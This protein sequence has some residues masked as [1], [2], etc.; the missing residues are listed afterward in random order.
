MATK[1]RYRDEEELVKKKEKRMRSRTKEI[2]ENWVKTKRRYAKTAMEEKDKETRDRKK[3][4]KHGDKEIKEELR[5]ERKDKGEK[6][7][8]RWTKRWKEKVMKDK[9]DER[10]KEWKMMKEKKLKQKTDWK[11]TKNVFL[12]T[13][14]FV[15]KKVKRE[16]INKEFHED[17][18]NIHDYFAHKWILKTREHK[19]RINKKKAETE[20]TKM[21]L[22]PTCWKKNEEPIF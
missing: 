7:I 8:K 11:T 9:M 1:I 13:S 2:K 20:K 6:R 3:N 10:K 16:R 22:S 21:S 14:F 12:S 5:K 17:F 19:K 18:Q 4:E 15:R